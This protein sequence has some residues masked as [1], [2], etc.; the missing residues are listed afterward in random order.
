MTK[1]ELRAGAH[2]Q[3]RVRERLEERFAG[4]ERTAHEHDRKLI[5]ELQFPDDRGRLA[6]QIAGRLLEDLAGHL[7]AV[8][9]RFRHVFRERSDVGLAEPFIH[10]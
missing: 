3:Y 1:D 6:G 10:E 4:L 8:G 5:L 7:V 2:L 9:G